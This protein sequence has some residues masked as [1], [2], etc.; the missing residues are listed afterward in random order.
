[1]LIHIPVREAFVICLP[2]LARQVKAAAILTALE[3][4]PNLILATRNQI[5]IFKD[6]IAPFESESF[7]QDSACQ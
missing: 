6:R 1:M 3:N 5:F 2:T 4:N 7:Q